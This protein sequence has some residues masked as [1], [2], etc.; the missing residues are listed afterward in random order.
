MLQALLAILAGRVVPLWFFPEQAAA[1]LKYLPFAW[2]AF[3]PAAVYLGEVDISEA[4][5]LLVIGLLWAL[6][7]GAVIA[8]LW[9]R[10]ARRLVVQGG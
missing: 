4:F 2:V 7:L 9:H 6:A 10:A 3:H 5:V 1:I 8:L